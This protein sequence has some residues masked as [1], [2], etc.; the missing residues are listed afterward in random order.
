MHPHTPLPEPTAPTVTPESPAQGHAPQAAR[1]DHHRRYPQANLFNQNAPPIPSTNPLPP[2]QSMIPPIPLVPQQVPQPQ[3]KLQPQQVP[4]PQQNDTQEKHRKGVEIPA[5]AAAVNDRKGSFT[6]LTYQPNARPTVV[7]PPS[8]TQL[9]VHVIDSGN[10]GPEF[11]RMST[12]GVPAT[13][14]MSESSS[15]PLGALVSPLAAPVAEGATIV[16]SAGGPHYEPIRCGRCGAYVNPHTVFLMDGTKMKCPICNAES[17][18]PEWYFS[19]LDMNGVRADAATRPELRLGTVEYDVT[20]LPIYALP[21][22]YIKLIKQKSKINR[23]KMKIQ[24]EAPEFLCFVIDVSSRALASGLVSLVSSTLRQAISDGTVNPSAQI[25]FVTYNKAVHFWELGGA[26]KRPALHKV[27]DTSAPPLIPRG[28]NF[29]VSASDVANPSGTATAAGFFLANLARLGQSQPEFCKAGDSALATALSCAL[30]LVSEESAAIKARKIV[31]FHATTPVSEPGKVVLR[32]S[33]SYY[34][35][36]FEPS[37]FTA[38]SPFYESFGDE[39]A[40]AGVGVD[41]FLF[42]ATYVDVASIGRVSQ[43]TGG[44]VHYFHRFDVA[45]DAWKVEAEVRRTFARPWGSS[46]LLRVRVS[47]GLSVAGYTGLV[48]NAGEPDTVRLATI[49]ADKAVS[50]TFKYDARSIDASDDGDSAVVVQSALLYTDAK[51]GCRRRLRVSTLRVPISI[52]AQGV[53]N[54]ADR[55]ATFA[56]TARIAAASVLAGDRLPA[57]IFSASTKSLVGTLSDYR[58]SCSRHTPP[59]QLVLPE[60]FALLPLS[61]LSMGKMALLRR[62]IKPDIR[63]AAAFQVLSERP[64]VTALRFHPRVYSLCCCDGD[65]GSVVPLRLSINA[66]DQD[67]VY[68]V[69]D[70]SRPLVWIG[71]RPRMDVLKDLFGEAATSRN[72][73]VLTQ[74]LSSVLQSAGD[75]EDKEGSAMSPSCLLRSLVRDAAEVRGHTNFAVTV[76]ND[77]EGLYPN[78]WQILIEDSQGLTSPSYTDYLK[79]LHN[80]ILKEVGQ[81]FKEQIIY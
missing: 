29:F 50:V 32:D 1:K 36:E 61:V 42:S 69:D 23:A 49:D 5:Q 15:F 48:S 17:A 28:G 51:G 16:A 14:D 60:A 4:Q 76:A 78:I 45:R 81:D 72:C 34:G 58:V 68:F 52:C 43:R 11:I 33:V 22:S 30:S 20:D 24:S 37:L 44:Q 54:G 53:Y 8:S 21:S 59:S 57:D 41:T 27:L 63:C 9:G 66:L 71:K 74:K 62:E 2:P 55:D 75:M 77:E 26:R 79:Q 25:A 10:C 73:A 56:L 6:Y 19:P 12:Y 64:A 31:L 3:Q 13:R 35:T 80:A 18:V 70:G 47:A 65:E 7:P 46:T 67:G 40:N 39:C 38:Y